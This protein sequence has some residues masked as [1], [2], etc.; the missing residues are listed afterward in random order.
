MRRKPRRVDDTAARL[1]Q[2]KDRVHIS[3]FKGEVE[4]VEV[5]LQPVFSLG[6]RKC[7]HAFLLHKPS[8]SDLGSGL[9]VTFGN[10]QQ[11]GF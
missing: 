3:F 6:S 4:D 2:L 10:P 8:Q 1:R 7:D 5:F 9:A 11:D